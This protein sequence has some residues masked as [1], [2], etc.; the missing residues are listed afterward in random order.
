LAWSVSYDPR[1]LKELEKLDRIAQK[2][3][4]KFLRERIEGRKN[5]RDLAK[6]LTGG[7]IRL[8]RYRVGDYRMICQINDESQMVL[9]LRIAHRKEAYRY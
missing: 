6:A 3:I 5:P 4:V 9:I 7:E 1:A 2:R 8:W